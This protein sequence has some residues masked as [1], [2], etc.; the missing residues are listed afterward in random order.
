MI[1]SVAT[2]A[3]AQ[4]L[5]IGGTRFAYRR[6]GTPAGIPLV[7]TQ[8]FMGN[9]DNFDPAISDPL[10]PEREIILFDNAG[11][12]RSTGTAPDTIV[13]LAAGAASFIDEGPGQT[14]R[15]TPHHLGDLDHSDRRT[16]L[17]RLIRGD[18]GLHPKPPS[19]RATRI[20]S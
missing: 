3:P 17:R 1:S 4:F 16:R 15:R 19:C 10:A 6:F 14:R 13:G 20:A 8:H 12:G 7:F 5:D 2:T 18:Q 11:V 9:L